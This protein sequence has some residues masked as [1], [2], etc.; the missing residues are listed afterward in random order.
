MKV[1]WLASLLL[2][3]QALPAAASDWQQQRMPWGDPDLQGIW[4]NATLTTLTRPDEFENLILNE[5]EAVLLEKYGLFGEED[6]RNIDD[7]PEGDL[8]AGQDVGGYNAAWMDP[9]LLFSSCDSMRC[10]IKWYIV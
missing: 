4:T 10:F 9:G 1:Q 3:L 6:K 2:A 5:E 7:L 8:Q